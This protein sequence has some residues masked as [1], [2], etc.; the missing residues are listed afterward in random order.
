MAKG[1]PND[2]CGVYEFHDI[3]RQL[4][5]ASMLESARRWPCSHADSSFCQPT[6]HDTGAYPHLC[7]S[8]RLTNNTLTRQTA[9]RCAQCLCRG[10]VLEVGKGVGV[11]E[12]LNLSSGMVFP[13]AVDV[14]V[15]PA[16]S[17]V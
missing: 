10:Q 5:V 16:A 2:N 8:T 1:Q 17:G 14:D 4:D 9:L 12:N 3:G 6:A 11:L 13:D 15:V 7:T